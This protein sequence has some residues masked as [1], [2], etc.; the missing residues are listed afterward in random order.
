MT[1]ANP[2]PGW[3]LVLVVIA[4]AVVAWLA[5]RRVPLSTRRRHALAT[6]RLVTLLWLILCLM[7]PVTRASE[8]TR[9]AIVPILVDASRSMGLADADGRRRIDVARSLVERQLL[10][11]IAPRFQAE[12]LRFG[13]SVSAAEPSMLSATD[14]RTALGVALQA[15]RDRY[16]GR[17]VAGIVLV[18]DGA[19]NG[20]VDAVAAAATGAPIFALGIGPK[21]SP[22][23]R[24]IVGVTAAESV[25]SDALVDVAVSAVSHGYGAAPI[26]LRL[27]E[28]GRPIDV[29]RI[30]PAA[31]GIPVSQT[32][33]VSP[34]RDVP[35]VYTV[36]VPATGDE[37]V[38]ENN[39]RSALVPA[40]ARP[41]RVL[42]VEGRRGSSTV[43]SGAHGPAIVV[44]KWTPSFVRDAMRAARIRFTCRPPNRAPTR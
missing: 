30:T 5:Y 8:D 14:R 2:L 27:L 1:F 15:V 3:A 36:E 33:R 18:S 10:P 13:D 29:R 31:D 38:T 9:D 7:R 20:D 21:T 43:S 42:F 34:N 35:T 40:A 16:R 44:S 25:L 6:L 19:D 28:N 12:L 11:A 39:A 37:I 17:P 41:R 22:R 32:F 23:D 26:E 24:E 4:A